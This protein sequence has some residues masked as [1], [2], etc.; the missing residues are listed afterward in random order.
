MSL[1]IILLLAAR[2]LAEKCT[3]NLKQVNIEWY[4]CDPSATALLNSRSRSGP[5]QSADNPDAGQLNLD[6]EPQCVRNRDPSPFLAADNRNLTHVLQ[7]TFPANDLSYQ[8]NG[9]NLRPK[10]ATLLLEATA[11]LEGRSPERECSLRRPLTPSDLPNGGEVRVNLV[12]PAPRLEGVHHA[13]PN[14]VAHFERSTE[15]GKRLQWCG[16]PRNQQTSYPVYH[17]PVSPS[18]RAVLRLPEVAA[19]VNQNPP[20]AILQISVW[21]SL[22]TQRSKTGWLPTKYIIEECAAEGDCLLAACPS[23]RPLVCESDSACDL[24]LSPAKFRVEHCWLRVAVV[25]RTGN[26]TLVQ[27]LEHQNLQLTQVCE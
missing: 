20:P 3:V 9:F 16:E 4:A 2:V 19:G 24:L 13:R 11:E 8:F 25:S 14:C 10:N 23:F 22:D 21:P 27:K 15:D 12:L 18:L 26:T 6:L 5:K 17:G 7:C 1:V